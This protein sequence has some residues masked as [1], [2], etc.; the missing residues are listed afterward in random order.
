[1]SNNSWFIIDDFDGFV[2]SSRSLVFKFFGENDESLTK[3]LGLS[4]VSLS[5]EELKELNQTLTFDESAA[6]IKN[7]AKKQINKKTK[8]IKYCIN[9]KL[10]MEIIE[11]LNS[12]LV[13]NILSS[14][15]S[16]GILDSAFDSDQNDFV[17]WIKEPLDKEENE[18][19]DKNNQS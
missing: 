5:K 8:E 18:N 14:L 4:S 17:F 10:L 1:M 6:I 9:D 16:K 7:K 3:E 19:N 11:D 2:D 15:V 12:R 13:S